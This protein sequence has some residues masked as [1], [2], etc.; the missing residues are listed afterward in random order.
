MHILIMQADTDACK[1]IYI[2]YMYV[3]VHTH[4]HIHTHRHTHSLLQT[5]LWRTNLNMTLVHVSLLVGVSNVL[6]TTSW[7]LSFVVTEVW[8]VSVR[9]RDDNMHTHLYMYIV[10]MHACTIYK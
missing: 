3:H 2:M 9:V 4:T 8:W 7:T 10:C 5:S 1:H 6:T